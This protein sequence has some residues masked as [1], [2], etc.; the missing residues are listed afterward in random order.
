MRVLCKIVAQW[1][2]YNGA[3][4]SWGEF[5]LSQFGFFKRPRTQ[6]DGRP[7]GV[8]RAKLSPKVDAGMRQQ[9]ELAQQRREQAAASAPAVRPVGRPP[10]DPA[11]TPP[12]R[13]QKPVGR[14]LASTHV[15]APF[16]PPKCLPQQQS[17]LKLCFKTP[18]TCNHLA[19]GSRKPW[20]FA[21]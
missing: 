18:Q 19:G 14:L 2:T 4:G 6:E 21:H 8:A 10:M 11:S 15:Q 7:F 9:E 1:K 3:P 16:P 13:E 20:K 17:L 12:P 5:T